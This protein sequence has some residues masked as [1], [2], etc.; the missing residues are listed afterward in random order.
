[1]TCTVL[2]AFAV[3]TAVWIPPRKP[4]KENHDYTKEDSVGQVSY[5]PLTTKLQAIGDSAFPMRNPMRT[6]YLRCQH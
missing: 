2:Q 4:L 5:V 1:M 3:V 6:F